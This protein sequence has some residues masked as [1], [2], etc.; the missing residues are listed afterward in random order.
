MTKTVTFMTR[1]FNKYDVMSIDEYIAIGGFTALKRAI[2][3][4]GEDIAR[5]IA[6][7]Q[8]KG[9]GGAAYDM[10]KKWSQAR[11][12]KNPEKVIVCNADE[13][14]PCTFKDRTLI[15]NDPFN[16]L[17]GMII[18]GYTMKAQNGYIYMREEYSHLRP[19]LLNAIKQANEKGY[20]GK[21]ILGVEGF[22]YQI[23]LYSGAGAYVCGEGTAL[24]ESIEGKAGRP[25]MKPPYIKQCG[26]YNLPTCVQN[27]ESLSLVAGI[28]NDGDTY[29]SYGPADCLGTK[30][31][32]VAGNVNRPG[33]YEIPFGMTVREIIYD[34]AGGV[35]GDRDI[36]LI[37]FG[38]ASG[39]IAPASVLDTPY[40]YD[41]LKGAGVGV[42][43]GAILVVD[44]RT[45]VI[46]FLTTTQQ[47]FSHESC[48]QC[49][50]CREGNLH[51]K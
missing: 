42:G 26:L 45:S 16:L 36:R 13:G 10:G 37:Q 4:D 27:V 24:V 49:A 19:I 29:K 47:F 38:G 28:L 51:I 11:S 44:E 5:E 33:V 3:M 2:T 14:E 40:T 22:D 17:E 34:L 48:G 30:L 31:V 9:R 23:H 8:V 39:K 18:A 35:Q 1:N 32:S 41:D 43:S 21:N 7:C 12:E 46:D 50:P 6:S 20:L 15:Q 25:R